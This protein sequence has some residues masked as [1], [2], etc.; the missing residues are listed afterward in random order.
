VRKEI[1]THLLAYNLIRTIIAQEASKHDVQPRSIS[2]KGAI[3][4]LEA[5]Q[6]LIAIQGDR[7]SLRRRL[8]YEQLLNTIAT[9]R[10]ADRPDRLNLG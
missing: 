4:I 7:N 10:V 3:Q 1:W 6:P 9:H 8:I 5:F 2:F